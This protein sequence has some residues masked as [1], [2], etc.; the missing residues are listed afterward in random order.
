MAVAP[1]AGLCAWVVE[2]KVGVRV[3]VGV[4]VRVGVGLGLGL[5][6]AWIVKH[7]VSLLFERHLDPSP[8]PSRT[9]TPTPTLTPAPNQVVAADTAV[10]LQRRTLLLATLRPGLVVQV[11]YLVITPSA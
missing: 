5:G 1:L 2:H 7:K 9:P 3:G 11:R 10:E 6:F 8:S 4:R